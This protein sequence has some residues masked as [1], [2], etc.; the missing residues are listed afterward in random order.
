MVSARNQRPRENI[1]FS[2]HFLPQIP[3][4]DLAN[5]GKHCSLPICNVQDLLPID[6]T[7]CHV[8][9]CREHITTDAHNC[10]AIATTV[11]RDGART[12]TEWEK[13]ARC[14]LAGCSNPTLSSAYSLGEEYAILSDR[15]RSTEP[16]LTKST[17]TSK[18]N[19]GL[20]PECKGAFC[21]A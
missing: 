4:M 18:V 11:N 8:P 15:V 7:S 21:A 6:C 10:P 16:D 14:E 5:I 3:T 12:S 17:N 20:C 13:R 19:D 9:F 1:V 2:S